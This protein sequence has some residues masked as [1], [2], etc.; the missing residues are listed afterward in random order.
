MNSFSQSFSSPN[1][2]SEPRIVVRQAFGLSSPRY[3]SF[4]LKIQDVTTCR[5]NACPRFVDGQ[6]LSILK[7]IEGLD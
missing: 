5:L 7:K 4:S 3:P 2:I 6:D 1:R